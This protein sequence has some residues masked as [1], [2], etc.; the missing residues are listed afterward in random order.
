LILIIGFKGRN[1]NI[2]HAAPPPAAG[3]PATPAQ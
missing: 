3:A 2:E 1:K